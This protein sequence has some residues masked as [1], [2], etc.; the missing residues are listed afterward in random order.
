[1]NLV[2]RFHC[3]GDLFNLCYGAEWVV[4]WA[5]LFGYITD[6]TICAPVKQRRS[7]QVDTFQKHAMRENCGVPLCFSF[8]S[9]GP[10]LFCLC[11]HIMSSRGVGRSQSLIAA[12][13]CGL[14]YLAD[15]NKAK[16]SWT[17][18]NSI[19]LIQYAANS[20]LSLRRDELYVLT[21]IT[22]WLS[23]ICSDFW[24]RAPSMVI[25]CGAFE[26]SCPATSRQSTMR[27]N[28]CR[29]GKRERGHKL[30]SCRAL[31][32]TVIYRT[33]IWGMPE[34][35]AKELPRN[36]VYKV[37]M[38]CY[39]HTAIITKTVSDKHQAK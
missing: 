32:T 12:L 15:L 16:G 27:E 39:S 11:V 13:L 4:Q 29:Y 19:A 3:E 5:S 8:A 14:H 38:L 28:L 7:C 33:H 2:E 21:M 18:M 9:R 23:D 36:W 24:G 17:E 35:R 1:M 10:T 25:T 6:K 31:S 37:D 26:M 30:F 20:E 34:K 22:Q